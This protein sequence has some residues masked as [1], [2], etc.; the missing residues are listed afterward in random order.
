[1]RGPS[2]AVFPLFTAIAGLIV[3]TTVANT[4]AQARVNVPA[5]SAVQPIVP[6]PPRNPGY[7]GTLSIRPAG[8]IRCRRTCVKFGRGTATHPPVCRQWR[9]VC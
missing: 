8:S 3:V 9:I 4:A 5:P 6:V 1:M 7:T 2:A